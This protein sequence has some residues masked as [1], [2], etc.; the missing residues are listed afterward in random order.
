ME[1]VWGSIPHSS[2][3]KGPGHS[4]WAFLV[5]ALGTWLGFYRVTRAVAVFGSARLEDAAD[6][7]PA[8]GQRDRCADDAP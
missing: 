3:D 8:G 2:T 4:T 5:P 1:E 6:E 7:H